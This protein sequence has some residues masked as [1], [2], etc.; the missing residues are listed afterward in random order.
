VDYSQPYSGQ[1]F[2]VRNDDGEDVPID[3]QLGKSR[4]MSIAINRARSIDESN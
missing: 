3:Q 4:G 1:L 2:T